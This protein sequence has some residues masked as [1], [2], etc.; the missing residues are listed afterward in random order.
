M[1]GCNQASSAIRSYVSERNFWFLGHVGVIIHDEIEEIK[2]GKVE[3]DDGISIHFS[4]AFVKEDYIQI[5]CYS[6]KAICSVVL[7][8]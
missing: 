6:I 4:L 8:I 3:S 2:K 1:H 7:V 5:S